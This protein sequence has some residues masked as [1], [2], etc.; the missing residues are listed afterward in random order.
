MSGKQLMRISE[1]FWLHLLLQRSTLGTHSEA[2]LLNRPLT[3]IVALSEVRVNLQTLSARVR[4]HIEE[5]NLPADLE[6]ETD[7]PLPESGKSY[8]VEP[9]AVSMAGIRAALL[10]RRV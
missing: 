9:V 10:V 2:G 4:V 5:L 1:R 8:K 3:A 6:W 7:G